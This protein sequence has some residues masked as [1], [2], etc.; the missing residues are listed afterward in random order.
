MTVQRS[1]TV[2]VFGVPHSIRTE[3]NLPPVL[4]VTIPKDGCSASV[5]AHELEF[6]LEEIEAVFVN[7]QV[8]S[9]DHYIQPGDRIAFVPTGPGPAR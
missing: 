7:H 4:E 3:R 8:Y 2:Q 1:T 5:L 9:L 6:P